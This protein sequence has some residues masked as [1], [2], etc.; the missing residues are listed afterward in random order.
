MSYARM[1]NDYN[2]YSLCVKDYLARNNWRFHWRDFIVLLPRQAMCAK[3]SVRNTVSLC[4][5]YR[6]D[7]RIDQLYVSGNQQA[8]GGGSGGSASMPVPATPF[9]SAYDE[10]GVFRIVRD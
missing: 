9:V 7:E 10:W 6:T 3:L 8:H 1:C 2:T 4:I 5:G